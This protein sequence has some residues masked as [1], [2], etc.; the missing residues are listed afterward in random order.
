MGP[1]GYS[2]PHLGGCGSGVS[3]NENIKDKS[4]LVNH[5][6]RTAELSQGCFC[7]LWDMWQSPMS[8][9][10]HNVKGVRIASRISLVETKD[11]AEHPAML[12]MTL[13]HQKTLFS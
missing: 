13:S 12:R 9:D 2:C 8:R 11:A 7:S 1:R 10:C 6:S 3:L 5:F 4:H